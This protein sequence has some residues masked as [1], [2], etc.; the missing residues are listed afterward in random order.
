[1][2]E[3]A[4]ARRCPFCAMLVMADQRGM[5]HERPACEQWIAKM[6]ELG[7]KPGVPVHALVVQL[8]AKEQAN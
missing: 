1:M 3:P 7:A 4:L 5:Y 6:A 8:G 2:T